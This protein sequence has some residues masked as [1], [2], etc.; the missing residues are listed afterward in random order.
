MATI[1]KTHSNKFWQ[2]YGEI[3]T[4]I[5]CSLE[6]KIMTKENSFVVPQEVKQN[7]QMNQQFYSYIYIQK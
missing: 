2:R 7:Y 4:L 1:K 5:H 3:R 6:C